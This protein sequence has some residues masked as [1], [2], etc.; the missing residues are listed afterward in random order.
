MHACNAKSPACN[1][2]GLWLTLPRTDPNDWYSRTEDRPWGSIPEDW[3]LILENWGLT[4]R[5]LMVDTWGLTIDTWGLRIDTWG[6]RVN[7]EKY[8]PNQYTKGDHLLSC[9]VQS[10]ILIC[11]IPRKGYEASCTCPPSLHLFKGFDEVFL[12]GDHTGAQNSRCGRTIEFSFSTVW[13][14]FVDFFEASSEF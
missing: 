2:V 3:R 7:S 14:S 13:N 5:T 12:V 10:N 4:L 6:L 11:H 9:I 8:Y 1:I